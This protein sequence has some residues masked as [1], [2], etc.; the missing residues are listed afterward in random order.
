MRLS[1]STQPSSTRR[2][3]WFGSSPVVSVSRTISRMASESIPFRRHLS[4][5]RENFTHLPARRLESLPAIHD[6]IGSRALFRVGQLLGGER[7]E[8]L[9]AHARALEHAGALHLGRRGHHH[10]RVAARLAAGFVQQRDVEHRHFGA[11]ARGLG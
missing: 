8:L 11:A 10:D 1:N 3:P 9:L 7:G 2:W 5:L 4:Y 6:E